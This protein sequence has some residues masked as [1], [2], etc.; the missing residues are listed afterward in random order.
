MIE[1]GKL[2][3]MVV[4]EANPLDDIRNI[5]KIS[6][7]VY[8]GAYYDRAALDAMLGKVEHLAN[9]KPIAEALSQTLSHWWHR[10]CGLAVSRA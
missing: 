6:A 1:S 8:D 5:L 3:D 2:A 7:L 9:R 10:C 4:L